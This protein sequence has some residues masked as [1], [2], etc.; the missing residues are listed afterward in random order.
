VILEAGVDG[1]E[2]PLELQRRRRLALRATAGSLQGVE[3]L[4]EALGLLQR[5]HAFHRIGPAQARSAG[6]SLHRVDSL[7]KRPGPLRRRLLPHRLLPARGTAGSLQHI[8]TLER[9]VKLLAS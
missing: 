2:H 1:L 3:G 8:P 9:L 4:A 5:R 7:T 6:G